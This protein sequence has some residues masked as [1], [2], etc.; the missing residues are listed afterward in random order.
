MMLAMTDGRYE[1][2]GKYME[3]VS[4]QIRRNIAHNI[5]CY[6]FFL[7]YPDDAPQEEIDI[8]KKA[9]GASP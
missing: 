6:D 8:V 9:A 3:T 1:E 7:T 4:P 5:C 2:F